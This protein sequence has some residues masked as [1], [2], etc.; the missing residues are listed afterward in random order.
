MIKTMIKCRLYIQLLSMIKTGVDI[1][2]LNSI[3]KLIIIIEVSA[4]RS[5][6]IFKHPDNNNVG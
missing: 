5:T 2:R 4:E 1:Y 3:S 6:E